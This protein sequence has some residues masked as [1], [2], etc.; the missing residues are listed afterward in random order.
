MK[1]S[2]IG[3]GYVGLPLAVE[4]SK[5]YSTTGYDINLKRIKDLK[6]YIDSNNEFNKKQLSSKR[7]IF[8]H[9]EN[10]LQNT[11]L[12][13]LTVPTPVF[14]NK[15]PN[16]NI[17]KT[18]CNMI[19]KYVKKNTII[20]NESTVYPG[21][22]EE[23]CGKIISKKTKLIFNKDFFLGYSPERINPGDKNH[24][25]NK[26][27]KLISASNIKSLNII[28]EV[29]SK[30]TNGNTI[31][32]NSIKIAEAAKVIENTQRDIN[33]AFMNE[34]KIIFSKNNLNFN[35]IL[36]A[37][38]TKWNFSHYHPGLVGGH[39]IGIDPYY[40]D[41]Y[42]N[43]SKYKSK[44]I[45]N[46][47][48]INDNMHINYFKDFNKIY[49]NFNIHQKNNNFKKI[50]LLGVTFKPNINDI[51]N[52][53]VV[54]LY[55]KLNSIYQV[56][57]CDPHV[58]ITDFKAMYNLRLIDLKNIDIRKYGAFIIAVKHNIILKF[59]KKSVFKKN[60]FIYEIN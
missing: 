25:L 38:S 43:K 59:V 31:K 15:K 4:A 23:I 1:I 21:V 20:V 39:C 28:N 48:I 50:L 18:A 5:Y 54:D 42:A 30:I 3:L 52:S 9:N 11:D 57:L 7:L 34:L 55:E 51:R 27:S 53:K 46:S 8:T 32:V 22:T 33:I 44:I 56:S 47:R 13:I 26:I 29:Y 45:K 6:K 2:I 40:I 37:A 49:K 16:L 19:A 35:K 60:Q 14:K 17:L 36:N 10:D 24:S 41:F 12:F 58:N